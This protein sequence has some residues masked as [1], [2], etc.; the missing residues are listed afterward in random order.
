MRITKVCIENYGSL[1]NISLDIS[2]FTVLIGKNGSGKSFLLEAIDKFFT[3]FNL[4]GGGTPRGVSDYLWFDRDVKKPIS[5]I[6]TFKLDDEEIKNIFPLS[7]EILKKIKKNSGELFNRLE[8]CRIIDYQKGWKTNYIRW[9]GQDLVRDDKILTP[10][11]L[12]GLLLPGYSPEP[13]PGYRMYFFEEGYSSEN[14][15]GNRLVVDENKKI[16]YTA[17]Q[18]IDSLV[19]QGVIQ[20]SQ[21]TVG[22][23]WREWAAKQGY[24]LVERA[25]TSQELPDVEP[26]ITSQLLRDISTNIT[27]KIKGRFRLIPAARNV[28]ATLG[29][30]T[31]FIEPTTLDSMRTLSISTS[32]EDELKWNKFRGYVEKFF[33]KRLEP[34]PN[35]I[36]IIDRD[37]RLPVFLLGGGEQEI[38]GLMWH[39]IEEGL[40]YGIEEP[41]NHLHPDISR[42]FLKFLK[43]LS[44]QNQILIV[45]HS[46]IF[47][48]KIDIQNNWIIWKEDKETKTRRIESREDFKLILWEL[49]VVPSDIYLK[50]FVVFVEGG[51]EKEAILPIFA[52]KLGLEDV[53]D[54]VAIISV[55][56][57]PQIKN[58]LRI[59]LEVVTYAPIDYLVLLDRHAETLAFELIREMNIDKGKFV[60]LERMCIED[61]YPIDLLVN[62]IN[63]LFGLEITKEDID[64]TRQRDKEIER[65][66]SENNKIRKGWKIQLGEYIAEKMSEKDIPPAIREVIERIKKLL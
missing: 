39:L 19:S 52:Q 10:E 24:S 46:P 45:T 4:T 15:G 55:G 63:E 58:Y 38:L 66:L 33:H 32:R 5:F 11:E 48:D 1:R 65:I 49:G 27:N 42:G 37:L 53:E 41:E 20:S 36:L 60:I 57:E 9:A 2:S 23:N 17:D 34:N 25:P 21:E 7:K 22:L 14:I 44:Q 43:E 35:Q 3:E 51:T 8:I 59:W 62:A 12:I 50:D 18:R 40:I 56:G 54:K 13:L 64:P 30:R 29:E 31:A 16:A 26:P 61:Y 28:K 47:V 6:F